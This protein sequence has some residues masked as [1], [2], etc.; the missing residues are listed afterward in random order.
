M[1]AF[2]WIDQRRSVLDTLSRQLNAPPDELPERLRQLQERAKSPGKRLDTALPDPKDVLSRATQRN[3]TSIVVERL[4]GVD[5]DTLRRFGDD[6]RQRSKSAAIALG[7]IIND[8][9]SIAI[10]LTADRVDA[11]LDAS[12][13]AREVGKVMGAGGGGKSDV[14]TAGGKDASKLDKGLEA[15][16][17]LLEQEPLK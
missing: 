16:K 9:P 12:K 14:A 10:M 15:A 4:D 3:G 13:L 7:A 2:D 1:G 11:G 6:L 5:E 17:R 8:K